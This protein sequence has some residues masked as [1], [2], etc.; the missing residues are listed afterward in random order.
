MED[1]SFIGTEIKSSCIYESNYSH[2]I[3]IYY[4]YLL[5]SLSLLLL[6]FILTVAVVCYRTYGF[7]FVLVIVQQ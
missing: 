3:I 4:H 6:L 5:L 1:G 2:S 7:Y